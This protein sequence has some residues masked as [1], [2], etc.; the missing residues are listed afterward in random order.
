VVVSIDVKTIL[1]DGEVFRRSGNDIDGLEI[2]QVSAGDRW[3][4]DFATTPGT[5]Y[6]DVTLSGGIAGGDTLTGGTAASETLTLASTVHA[7]RGTINIRDRVVLISENKT[8]SAQTTP[9]ALVDVTSSRTLTMSSSTSAANG[10]RAVS[11]APTVTLGAAAGAAS[12]R[13]FENIATIKNDTSTRTLAGCASFYSKP[14][15]TADT[16]TLTVT[17][18]YGFQSDVTMGV[19]NGGTLAIPAFAGLSS[20]ATV[21]TGVTVTT[22]AHVQVTAPTVSG[23]VT[24]QYGVVIP[25]LAEATVNIGLEN[26]STTV[27]TPSQQA[28]TAVGDTIR[29]DRT[30]VRLN[31]TSGSSKT[32]TSAPTMADGQSGQIII[33]TNT[34]AN[35]IVLQDQGT[36]ASSNL[37]LVSTSIT[38]GTRDSVMLRYDSNV[39][40]WI[41]LTP[42]VNVL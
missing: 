16:G 7:T 15:I 23:T 19:V 26:A 8:Y 5:M 20:T 35:D 34:S 17:A 11:F 30:T 40:D 41:Q 42:V 39:G 12:H 29:I 36:L 27:F 13:I 37:R 6:G 14:T 18:A 22:L 4:P 21:G 32:L 9:L 38:L 33:L 3:A 2:P 28:I 25:A 10:L 31:N 1:A 24:T